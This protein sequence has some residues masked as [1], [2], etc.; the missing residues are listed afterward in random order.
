MGIVACCAAFH[1]PGQNFVSSALDK[2]RERIKR[3]HTEPL[4]C[5]LPSRSKHWEV[6]SLR[7]MNSLGGVPIDAITCAICA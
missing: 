3:L 5:Y 7:G 2:P 4:Y 1:L 6:V